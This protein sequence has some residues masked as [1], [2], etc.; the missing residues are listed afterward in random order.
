LWLPPEYRPWRSAIHDDTL[1]LGS[2]AGRVSFM[3]FT[4]DCHSGLI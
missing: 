3:K 2:A 1:V 4:T